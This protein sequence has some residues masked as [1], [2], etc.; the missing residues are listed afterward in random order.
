[1]PFFLQRFLRLF[2]I[3]LLLCVS[4]FT[5]AMSSPL[6]AVLIAASCTEMEIGRAYVDL[7]ESLHGTKCGSVAHGH[8]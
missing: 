5:H 4:R 1:L 2:L 7:L 3:V 8:F 6:V